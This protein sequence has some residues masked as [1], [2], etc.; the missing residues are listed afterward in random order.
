MSSHALAVPPRGGELGVSR[1]SL[2]QSVAILVVDDEPGMRNFLQR[3]LAPKCALL[4]VAASLEEAEALRQRLHFDLLVVDVRL[5]PENGIRWLQS[6]RDRGVRTHVIYMTAY[7][8]LQMAIEALR[9]GAEDFILKPFRIDQMLT[10]IYRSLECQHMLRENALLKRQLAKFRNPQGIVGNSERMRELCQLAE[11]VAPTQSTVLIEGE[12]GVGKELVA[13]AIHDASGRKGAF[14]P[15]NCGTI[16]ADL[17]ESELFGHAKGAFTGAQH[18]R[19]GLFVYADGG[20][21]FLDEIG[22]MPLPMQTKLLRVLEQRAVRPIGLEKE[23]PVDVRVVA[24]THRNLLEQVRAGAFRQDLYYRLNVMPLRV[25][26]LRERPEDIPLLA[27]FF[28]QRLSNEMSLPVVPLH[29]ADIVYLQSYPWP[30]NV[31][32]LKNIIERTLLL[33]QLPRDFFQEE[34]PLLRNECFG[35][36]LNWTVQEVECAHMQAVLGSVEGNKSEAARRLGVSRKTLERKEHL[37]D[38]SENS[39]LISQ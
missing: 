3:A 8:D 5:G 18:S 34:S 20:T 22:E 21:I 12:T 28:M 16:S 1:D 6:L 38:D 10:A 11:R 36:P 23:V 2:L 37:W 9:T 4:E 25:P 13:S 33:G 7:A 31:R 29:H 35:F 27:E 26:A 39:T 32:E 17:L 24:A 14:V 30:G 19:E 15:L